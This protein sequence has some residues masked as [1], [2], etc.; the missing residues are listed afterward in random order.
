MTVMLRVVLLSLSLL[1]AACE[2]DYRYA[3]LPS[4]ANVVILGDSL[5]YGT[6]AGPEQSYAAI[7]AENT[8][9]QIV[10]AGVPGDTSAEG[11]ERLPELLDT[12]MDEE[13]SIDL[14]LVELGGNDFLQRVPR[15]QTIRNLEAILAQ[16]KSRGV[17]TALIAIPK[18]SVAD[19]ALGNLSDHPLYQELA[20]ATGTPLI[21]NV[22]S[23]VLSTSSLKADAIHPNAHGY[24]VAADRL[25]QELVELGFIVP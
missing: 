25:Q 11:L 6:G 19:A 10:N 13:Q 18:I 1:L 14:L 5:T 24:R 3:P 12:Y 17:Q 15:S 4:A 7:L 16:A 23:E 20:E 9:W 21:E 8:G 22:F 2:R